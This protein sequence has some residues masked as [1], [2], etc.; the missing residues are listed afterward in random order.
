MIV[1]T[2]SARVSAALVRRAPARSER[3]SAPTTASH[4]PDRQA[5]LVN[6]LMRE[7]TGSW[8]KTLPSGGVQ[9]VTRRNGY[10]VQRTVRPDGTMSVRCL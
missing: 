7:N 1:N 4:A 2:I 10:T 3:R 8:S 9:I 5:L 6:C